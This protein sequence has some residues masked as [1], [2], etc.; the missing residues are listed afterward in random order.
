MMK[1]ARLKFL[2]H[3]ASVVS[4]HWIWWALVEGKTWQRAAALVAGRRPRGGREG[5]EAALAQ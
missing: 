5:G 4:L 3:L 2:E 1:S